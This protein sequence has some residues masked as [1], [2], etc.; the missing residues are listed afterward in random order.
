LLGAGHIPFL[1]KKMSSFSYD[2]PLLAFLL[3]FGALVSVAV[4][5]FLALAVRKRDFGNA[6]VAAVMLT[7]AIF[8]WIFSWQEGYLTTQSGSPELEIGDQIEVKGEGLV[9]RLMQVPVLNRGTGTARNCVIEIEHRANDEKEYKYLGYAL[10]KRERFA[11]HTESAIPLV[12]ANTYDG[13]AHWETAFILMDTREHP[14]SDILSYPA[15]A[16]DNYLKLTMI[17]DNAKSSPREFKLH[18]S[19]DGTELPTLEVLPQREIQAED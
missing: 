9:I 2:S 5:V 1:D 13:G 6:A 18:V 17:S 14:E 8:G 10:F 7:V 12:R 3:L 19:Q 15:P 4:I 11:P 16:G